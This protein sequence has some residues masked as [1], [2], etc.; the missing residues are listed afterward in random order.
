MD[1]DDEL[2]MDEYEVELEEEEV[3][4]SKEARI[5]L[6]IVMAA[7]GSFGNRPH[8]V[9]NRCQDAHV[10]TRGKAPVWPPSAWDTEQR[11]TT[12]RVSDT[13]SWTSRRATST[14]LWT[15][16]ATLSANA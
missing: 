8:E 2:E 16:V 3:V 4:L 10:A 9:W 11:P 1:M 6:C 7:S 15:H 14:I 12:K 5:I 13:T